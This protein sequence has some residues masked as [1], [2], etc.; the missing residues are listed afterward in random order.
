V[1]RLRR[2]EERDLACVAAAASDSQRAPSPSW[3]RGRF[4]RASVRRLEALV[5]PENLASMRALDVCGFQK[6]G[7]LRS[8]L[9]GRHDAF[10]YSL[11]AGD[12]DE[13]GLSREHWTVA[14]PIFTFDARSSRPR[15]Y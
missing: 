1:V 4:S 5:D 15:P 6:E 11:L 7:L 3:R 10:I 8:Y 12:L 13:I 14:R 2:W 9:K